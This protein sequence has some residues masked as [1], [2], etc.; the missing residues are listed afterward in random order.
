MDVALP[1]IPI[2]I[3]RSLTYLALGLLVESCSPSVK[4]QPA[5]AQDILR[6][7]NQSRGSQAVLV[8]VWATWCQPCVEEFPL[9]VK[10]DR[11]YDQLQTLFVSADFPEDK[12]RVVQFLKRQGVTGISFLKDQ[13]DQAFIDG[14]SPDWSG[15]LPFTLVFGKESGTV[16]ARWEGK[17]TQEQMEA[18][19]RLAIQ[20]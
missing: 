13:S 2:R 4:L 12:S 9:L 10:L 7:V 16:V 5:T 17:R 20:N 1:V 19:I 8:N 15:T 3:L 11:R 14:L 6:E 18:A